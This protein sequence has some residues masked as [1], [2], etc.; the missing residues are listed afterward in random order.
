MSDLGES[1]WLKASRLYKLAIADSIVATALV[2][3]IYI[4]IPS[5]LSSVLFSVGF[6]M[7]S[8]DIVN[9]AV[10]LLAASVSIS[11]ITVSVVMLFSKAS[12]DF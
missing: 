3:A 2:C 4:F 10:I 9:D 7:P 12:Y 5:L 11:I 1:F 8:I 6:S